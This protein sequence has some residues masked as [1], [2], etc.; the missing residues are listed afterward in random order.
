MVSTSGRVPARIEVRVKQGSV[1]PLECSAPCNLKLSDGAEADLSVTADGY[2][3]AMLDLSHSTLWTGEQ[4]VRLVVP[5][6][7]AGE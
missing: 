5:L 1:L 4:S 2:F 7:K 6:L 3:P